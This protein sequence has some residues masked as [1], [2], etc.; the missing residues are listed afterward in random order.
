MVSAG[1]ALVV[2]DLKNELGA[3]E[4]ALERLAL[5]PDAPTAR[6]A[7]QQC[8]ALRQ[9]LVAYLALY[10]QGETLNAVCEDESPLDLLQLVAR[11]QLP[12]SAAVRVVVAPS[13]E[14]PA[15]WYFDR[16]LVGMALDAAVHNALR[17][18]RSEVVLGARESGAHLV[19]SVEDDGP[20]LD[21]RAE[22]DA[23]ATGLGTALCRAVARCHGT[24][25]PDG[26]VRL[27]NREGSAGGAR[28]EL[29][30]AT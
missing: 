26:G 14:A 29:W 23:H 3:L 20:G 21:P 7:Q 16:R 17:F 28:F 1:A 27:F 24:R 2:H 10:G 22:P 4:A 15:F 30:L 12:A 13:P 18:A 9:R 8:R 6:A 25:R 19:F 5:Q 11:R